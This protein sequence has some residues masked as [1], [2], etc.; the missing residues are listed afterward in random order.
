MMAIVGALVLAQR[1]HRAEVADR[2]VA[3]TVDSE[4][5]PPAPAAESRPGENEPEKVEV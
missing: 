3:A 4:L 5:L 1:V 2:A